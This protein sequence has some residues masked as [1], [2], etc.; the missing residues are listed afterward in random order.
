VLTSFGFL[1]QPDGIAIAPVPEPGTVVLSLT[2]LAFVGIMYLR[3]HR[4]GAVKCFA[5]GK[6]TNPVLPNDRDAKPLTGD[7]PWDRGSYTLSHI[8]GGRTICGL[9]GSDTVSQPL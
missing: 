1:S 4:K 8:S 7:S 2:A 9:A 6:R 5:R 3:R